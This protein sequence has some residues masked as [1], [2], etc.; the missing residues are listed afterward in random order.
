[1]NV[2]HIVGPPGSGKS[3]LVEELTL[4]LDVAEVRWQDT[5]LCLLR[6]Y[7]ST[8]VELGRLPTEEKP[9]R[10]SDRLT[11]NAIEYAWPYV[12]AVR[13]G[14]LLIEGARLE[15]RSWIAAL[16]GM[17]YGY[18]VVNLSVPKEVREVRL[19]ER[20]AKQDE[21]WAAARETQTERFYRDARI[22]TQLDGT[23]EPSALTAMLARID[24]VA[25]ALEAAALVACIC[26][27]TP[28][29]TPPPVYMVADET[30]VDLLP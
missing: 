28:R 30:Q 16:E 1:M 13:P 3:R 18:H 11:M 22:S 25:A 23:L 14:L 4:G 19:G 27:A 7:P 10:G 15:A 26:R 29:E 5:P 20:G 9:R 24:P 12:R 8:V 17:G 21:R 2:L 6:Y